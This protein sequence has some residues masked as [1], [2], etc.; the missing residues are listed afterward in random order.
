MGTKKVLSDSRR[1][2][3]I[4]ELY[5]IRD[6]LLSFSST[7]TSLAAGL[8]INQAIEILKDDYVIKNYFSNEVITWK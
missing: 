3:L 6:E 5:S 1:D 2:L 4:E 8:F 7:D